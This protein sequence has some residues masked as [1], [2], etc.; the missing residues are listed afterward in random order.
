M[1]IRDGFFRSTTA[2]CHA[3]FERFEAAG[4]FNHPALQGQGFDLAWNA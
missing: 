3:L 4:Q 1:R 2:F